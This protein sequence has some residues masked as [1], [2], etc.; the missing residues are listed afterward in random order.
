MHHCGV[1]FCFECKSDI[2]ILSTSSS[3]SDRT[4]TSL[5]ITDRMMLRLVCYL[6]SPLKQYICE[7][8]EWPC[9]EKLNDK[10]YLTQNNVVNTATFLK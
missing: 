7:E 1:L 4:K 10:E 9:I 8:L 2:Y 6:L 3:L 5:W